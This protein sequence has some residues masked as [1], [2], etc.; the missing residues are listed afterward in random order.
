MDSSGLTL[1]YSSKLRPNDAAV[2]L[3]GSVG[4]ELPPGRSEVT[5]VGS[6]AAQCTKEEFSGPIYVTSA[7][8]HMHY[9]GEL[10]KK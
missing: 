10:L 7:L 9:L 8:N 3:I 1:Y 2:M 4:F 5:V 6:C